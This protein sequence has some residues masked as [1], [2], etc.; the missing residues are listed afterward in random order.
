[1]FEEAG[2][3]ETDGKRLFLGC[4]EEAPR[5]IDSVFLGS[6][7]YEA[8]VLG[9]ELGVRLVCKVARA[10]PICSFKGR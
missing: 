6:P 10:N 8:E 5:C 1:V 9:D 2:H 4:I 3:A 7:Q